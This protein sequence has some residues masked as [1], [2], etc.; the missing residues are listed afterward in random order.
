MI[1]P[2]TSLTISTTLLSSANWNP[3]NDDTSGIGKSERSV[4]TIKLLYHDDILKSVV[5]VFYSGIT[6]YSLY[7]ANFTHIFI[8]I[9]FIF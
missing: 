4:L 5:I 3:V 2:Y 1:F 6:A 8:C 7:I 9:L